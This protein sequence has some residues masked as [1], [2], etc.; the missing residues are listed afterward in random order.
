MGTIRGWGEKD[1]CSPY[2]ILS[3]LGW[4]KMKGEN[5]KGRG[6]IFQQKI[7]KICR[8]SRGQGDGEMERT[9]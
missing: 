9:G 1:A 6:W 5:E 2:C 3:D 8:G 7:L 4:M